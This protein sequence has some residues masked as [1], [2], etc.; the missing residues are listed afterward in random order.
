MVETVHR[1]SAPLATVDTVSLCKTLL[2]GVLNIP[3]TKIHESSGNANALNYNTDSSTDVGLW[4][5]N[6]VNWGQCN[7]GNAPCDLNANLN[8][9]IKVYGWG[10]NTW[11]LWSTAAGCGC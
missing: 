5:I 1:E 10:G 9:A 3:G 8:C 6:T 7:G 2:L 4:Q 11:R